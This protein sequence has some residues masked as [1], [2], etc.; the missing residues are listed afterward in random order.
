[1]NFRIPIVLI[2]ALVVS[3]G[4][5]G[6]STTRN[7]D[8]MTAEQLHRAAQVRTSVAD[9]SGAV[10][11]LEK[12]ESR[13]PFSRE[14]QHAQLEL[15][16]AH[17]KAGNREQA[18]EASER[19]LREQPRHPDLDYVHYLRGLINFGTELNILD[20][21]FGVDPAKRD[22]T[23]ARRS[24]QSFSTLVTNHPESRYAPDAQQ[25]MVHLRNQLARYETHVARYYMR[26]GAW[27]AAANRARDVVEQYNETPSA[28]DAL[29]ILHDAYR[30]LEMDDLAEDV[31]RVI[32][33]NYPEARRR[34]A[35]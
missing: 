11:Y 18:L 3:A 34:L 32:V 29:V 33:A 35:R 4:C 16:F 14:A 25:R 23:F 28:V 22:P 15:I 20:S 27:V 7:P 17:Y 5:S 12:L 9:Y 19:F 21:A 30:K 10:E 8:R 24:Y 13:F 6:A 1:M 31:V 2:L 26:L